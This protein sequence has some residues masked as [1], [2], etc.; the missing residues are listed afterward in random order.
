MHVKQRHKFNFEGITHSGK[1]YYEA[2]V[3]MYVSYDFYGYE[4]P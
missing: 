3:A 1:N 2:K 4:A